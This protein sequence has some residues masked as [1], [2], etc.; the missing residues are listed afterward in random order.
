MR[1]VFT[2]PSPS[3]VQRG[4]IRSPQSLWVA[5]SVCLVTR[6]EL[7]WP[8]TRAFLRQRKAWGRNVIRCQPVDWRTHVRLF[9]V[10]AATLKKR[11][12]G[13][14]RDSPLTLASMF[15]DNC[16]SIIHIRTHHSVV[17]NSFHTCPATTTPM[18]WFVEDKDGS[19][20]KVLGSRVYFVWL[21]CKVRWEGVSS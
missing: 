9:H 7:A 17:I 4:A 14:G 1:D 15:S 2:S 8:F 19:L 18:V 11:K 6:G 16:P 13:E 3:Q 5:F 12:E 20:K 10:R 21:A